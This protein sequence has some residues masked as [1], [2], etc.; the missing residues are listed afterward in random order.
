[1]ATLAGSF[2]CSLGLSVRSILSNAL[3]L[4]HHSGA[5]ASVHETLPRGEHRFVDHKP[6][7]DNHQHDPDHLV[8]GAELAPVMEQMTEPEPSQDRD[9][10]LRRHQRTPSEGPTLLH[11]S[12]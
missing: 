11:P 5:P 7:H 2:F 8:H 3:R 9:I 1:V 10:D 4:L 6:D 12:D